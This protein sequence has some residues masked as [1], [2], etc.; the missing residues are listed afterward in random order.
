MAKELDK[1]NLDATALFRSCNTGILSTISKKYEG[2]PFGSFITYVS[3]RSK[4]I[5]LY[6]S[7]LAQ[8]TKN[9]N[10]KP[11]SC[12]TISK[13]TGQKDKQNSQRLT[14]M[15]DLKLVPKNDLDDCRYLY[16]LLLPESKQYAGF[17]DFNF[18]QLEIKHVRWIGGFGKIKWLNEE[19]WRNSSPKWLNQEEGIISHMNDDHSNS[20]ISTLNA[21]HGIKDKNAKMNKLQIDGYFALSNGKEYFLKFEQVCKSADEYKTELIKHAKKYRSYEL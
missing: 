15:G 11:E 12:L 19:K 17:H 16:H 3:G 7:D 2:Y 1:Y 13:T 21:Q 9:L 10:F 20:I 14:L 4:I 18:Y 6:L 8:H 5:Y